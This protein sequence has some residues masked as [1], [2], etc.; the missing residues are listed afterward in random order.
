M[1]RWQILGAISAGFVFCV[2]IVAVVD[3]VVQ[4][5][6]GFVAGWRGK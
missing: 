4:Y 2:C 1:T 3:L 6:R 5:V